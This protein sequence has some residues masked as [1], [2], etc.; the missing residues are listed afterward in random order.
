[1]NI[2]QLKAQFE[3]SKLGDKKAAA[4]LSLHY[5]PADRNLFIVDLGRIPSF[6]ELNAIY[7]KNI[8]GKNYKIEKAISKKL[9][10]RVQSEEYIYEYVDASLEADRN[11]LMRQRNQTEEKKDFDKNR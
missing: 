10:T 8:I 2:Y 1:M 5:A 3:K 11:K 6:E 7:T 9:S 4:S